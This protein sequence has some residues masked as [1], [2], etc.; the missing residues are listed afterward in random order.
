MDP[1]TAAAVSWCGLERGGDLAGSD[2]SPRRGRNR[3]QSGRGT[4][5]LLGHIV[6]FSK[7]SALFLAC[8]SRHRSSSS[9]VADSCSI[10][11][12]AMCLL[13]DVIWAP[14]TKSTCEGST[15][16]E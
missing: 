6:G 13:L 5:T 16:D 8:T 4:W 15:Y 9:T 14:V 2:R 1:L 7:V 10:T 12:G 11:E 3:L